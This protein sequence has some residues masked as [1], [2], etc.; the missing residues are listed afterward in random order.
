MCDYCSWIDQILAR[1]KIETTQPAKKKPRLHVDPVVIVHG[2]AGNLPRKKREHMLLEVTGNLIL[3]SITTLRGVLTN[4]IP[5][6]RIM[7]SVNSHRLKMQQS[8]R[9]KILSTVSRQ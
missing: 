5:I 7:T 6:T 4:C 2:G 1:I 8:K 3:R 9:T